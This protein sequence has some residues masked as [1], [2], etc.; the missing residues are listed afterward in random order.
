[1]VLSHQEMGR[2]W[3]WGLRESC[4]GLSDWAQSWR[5]PRGP[6]RPLEQS[7]YYTR[8]AFS[9]GTSCLSPRQ[10]LTLP[11]ALVGAEPPAAI[12]AS[13]Y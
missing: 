1:M 2:A 5:R 3:H 4:I 11:W 7:P 8:P 13:P 10:G 12:Q 6:Q 9:K